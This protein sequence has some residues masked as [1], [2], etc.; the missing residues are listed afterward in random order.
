MTA[1]K[2]KAEGEV[3]VDE[4]QKKKKKKKKK[5]AEQEEESIVEEVIFLM[6]KLTRIFTYF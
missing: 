6:V 4:P 1:P 2:R 5:A 3:D